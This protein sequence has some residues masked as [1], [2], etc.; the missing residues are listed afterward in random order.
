MDKEQKL[1]PYEV[2]KS[3][4]YKEDTPEYKAVLAMACGDFEECHHL[5][6]VVLRELDNAQQ[7]IGHGRGHCACGGC[8]MICQGVPTK[9][10]HCA[11]CA[12][13]WHGVGEPGF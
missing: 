6:L 2:A 1:T 11:P 3:W 8:P 10:D 7:D 4:G 9:G 12:N 13:H 5:C